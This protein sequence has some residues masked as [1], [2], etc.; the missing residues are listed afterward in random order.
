MVNQLLS[1]TLVACGGPQYRLFATTSFSKMVGDG[2]RILREEDDIELKTE[3]R[4]F[5]IKIDCKPGFSLS[6]GTYFS[7]HGPNQIYSDHYRSIGF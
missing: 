5:F 4:S 1:S 6:P 2:F 7:N 3:N